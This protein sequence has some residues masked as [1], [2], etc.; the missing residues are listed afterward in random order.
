MFLLSFEN[1]T[2]FIFVG[3]RAMPAVWLRQTI[4][5]LNKKILFIYVIIYV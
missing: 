4:S 1:L 5:N 2:F 3:S